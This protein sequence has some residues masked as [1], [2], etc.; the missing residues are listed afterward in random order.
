MSTALSLV[1]MDGTEIVV[2]ESEDKFSETE[3]LTEDDETYLNTVSL[4]KADE[5]SETQNKENVSETQNKQYKVISIDIEQELSET[6][7]KELAEEIVTIDMEIKRQNNE[8]ENLKS[9]STS[10]KKSIDTLNESRLEKSTDY[11]YG[12][13]QRTYSCYRRENYELGLYEYVNI[14]SG[15]VI[16]TEPFEEGDIFNPIKEEEFPV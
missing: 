13:K 8:L 12:K 15:A 1:R 6:E 5:V 2:Y 9:R 3:Y 7:L 16:K 10:L 14:N 11:D 4:L